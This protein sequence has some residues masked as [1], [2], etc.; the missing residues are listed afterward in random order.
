MST[1]AAHLCVPKQRHQQEKEKGVQLGLQAYLRFFEL[2]Q[3]SAKNKNYAEFVD[4][5]YYN[6]FVAF[7][8]YL[9]AIHAINPTAYIEWVIK[10]NKKLDQWTKDSFYEEYLFSYLRKESPQDAME[11]A[12]RVT[13]DWADNNNSLFNH[14]FLYAATNR[15]CYDITTGKISPWVIYNCDSGKEFLS[16]LNLEQIELIFKWIDTDFWQ[17]KFKDYSADTI[18]TQHILKGAGM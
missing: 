9:H 4:S 7:G 3:G 13:Q 1:L 16:K 15:V 6:A 8:R 11:R 5:P 10:N 12:L 14:Y 17:Q 2:T 18:W